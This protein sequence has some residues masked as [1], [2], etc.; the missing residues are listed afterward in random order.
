[1]DESTEVP[2]PSQVTS[3]LTALLGSEVSAPILLQIA[4]Y[5]IEQSYSVIYIR[6]T[7]HT[8][9]PPDIHGVS[10]IQENLQQFSNLLRFLYLPSWS[11]LLQFLFCVHEAASVPHVVLVENLNFYCATEPGVPPD[12][13]HAAL[14]LASLKDSVTACARKLK[15]S[16]H[17]VCSFDHVAHKDFKLHPVFDIFFSDSIWTVKEHPDNKVTLSRSR[18]IFDKDDT[19]EI[20]FVKT[21]DKI[22]YF[23]GIKKIFAH[24]TYH[25]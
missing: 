13:S 25:S 16:T 12:E 7:P 4:I 15:T 11:D 24:W 22:L 5:W 10:T 21:Q 18:D 2:E 3:H 8:K 23:E 17:L 20:L 6:P 1:M 14:I 9:L 19:D